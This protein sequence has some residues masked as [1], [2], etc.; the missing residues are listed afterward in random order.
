MGRRARPIDV[1]I[2]PRHVQA[3]HDGY[4]HR[5]IIHRR[6]FEFCSNRL[7]IE[8]LLGSSVPQIGVAHFHLHPDV[9]PV[10][11]DNS[12]D[13]AGLSFTFQNARNVELLDYDYC[14][15]FNARLP[16]KKIAVTFEQSLT[17]SIDYENSIHKR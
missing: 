6:R 10:L 17:T 8:D 4:R 14:V 5:G 1:D 15:G 7:E 16:A 3:A 9:E 12:I 2:G 11:I 13:V